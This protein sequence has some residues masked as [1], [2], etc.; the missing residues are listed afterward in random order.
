MDEGQKQSANSSKPK[1]GLGSGGPGSL[2]LVLRRIGFQCRLCHPKTTFPSISVSVSHSFSAWL[3]PTLHP[4]TLLSLFHSPNINRVIWMSY[5]AGKLWWC[6][7][8]CANL[9]VSFGSLCQMQTTRNWCQLT[10]FLI[11]YICL[12]TALSSTRRSKSVEFYVW[13]LKWP[14]RRAGP[15]SVFHFVYYW[16]GWLIANLLF[17]WGSSIYIP[18]EQ[19]S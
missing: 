7:L 16:Q 2:I 5:I 17:W 19:T 15:I 4:L 1:Q 11:A 9:S 3:S 18:N 13:S 6:Q 12:L 8:L 14:V 10:F